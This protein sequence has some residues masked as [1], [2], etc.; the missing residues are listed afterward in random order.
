MVRNKEFVKDINII[1]PEF[2][3]DIYKKATQQQKEIRTALLCTTGHDQNNRKYLIP[4]YMK[5]FGY[6]TA[7]STPGVSEGEEISKVRNLCYSVVGGA[8]PFS[9]IDSHTHPIGTGKYWADK[10]SQ[11]DIQATSNALEQNSNSVHLLATPQKMITLG[12]VNIG[13]ILAKTSNQVKALLT[14]RQQFWDT[15]YN[16]L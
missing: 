1:L 5:S 6:G 8:K 11:Q 2:F 9:V 15:K 7:V 14:Q 16:S 13:L 12:A 10:P 4:Q 3:Y